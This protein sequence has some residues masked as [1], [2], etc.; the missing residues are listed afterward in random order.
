MGHIQHFSYS[1]SF[2]NQV[3]VPTGSVARGLAHL[4]LTILLN[5]VA[6]PPSLMVQCEDVV[7]SC[8]QCSLELMTASPLLATSVLEELKDA[9][10]G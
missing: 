4:I 6:G 2:T 1:P 9:M 7:R 8:F 10:L 5:A 3:P